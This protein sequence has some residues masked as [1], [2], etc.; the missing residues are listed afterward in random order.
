[1]RLEAIELSSVLK[2]E[3][4]FPANHV[5][6]ALGNICLRHLRRGSFNKASPS[7]SNPT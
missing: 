2:I 6:C 1:M 4:P 7:K 3:F 5:I